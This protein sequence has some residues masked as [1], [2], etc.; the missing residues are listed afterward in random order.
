MT[1]GGEDGYRLR[2]YVREHG[3]TRFA[4]RA[5][6][7]RRLVYQWLVRG[8]IPGRWLALVR[9]VVGLGGDD[10]RGRLLRLMIDEVGHEK[11]A[12]V[13]G[14]RLPA[15]WAWL[16][17]DEYPGWLAKAL[18]RSF[19]LANTRGWSDEKLARFVAEYVGEDGG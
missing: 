16:G 18:V 13:L 17:A 12:K 10:P 14:V 1:W 3:V 11:A 7:D 8:A 15:M 6:V 9:G 5:G 2:E 19:R 4:L